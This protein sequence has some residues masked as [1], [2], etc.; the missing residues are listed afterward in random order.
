MSREAYHHGDLRT[1]LVEEAVATIEEGGLDALSV[2][3]LARRAGVSH[4]APAH[5]FGDRHGLVDAVIGEGFLR[6]RDALASALVAGGSPVEVG[7]AY[8]RFAL[9]NPRLFALMFGPVQEPE[10][11]TTRAAKDAAA[12]VLRESVRKDAPPAPDERRRAVAAWATTHGLAVLWVSGQI[13]HE[14][15][16]SLEALVRAVLLDAR[17]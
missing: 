17:R 2:R 6:L 1:A 9:D 3:S 8:S 4:A 5:H 14:P 11:A 7:V 13:A 12:A 15:D 10:S 16:A